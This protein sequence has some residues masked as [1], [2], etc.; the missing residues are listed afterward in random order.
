[1]GHYD[2]CAVMPA[3]MGKLPCVLAVANGLLDTV[4]KVTSSLRSGA[5][6]CGGR[7]TLSLEEVWR[8]KAV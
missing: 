1:M 3:T 6:H 5:L 8:D 2:A 7:V 4:M